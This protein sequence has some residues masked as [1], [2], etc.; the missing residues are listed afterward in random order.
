[1]A[2]RIGIFAAICIVSIALMVRVEAGTQ[3]GLGFADST[4]LRPSAAA[5][6]A[7]AGE[8]EATA[9]LN[10]C[11]DSAVRSSLMTDDRPVDIDLIRGNPAPEPPA[12]L[13][14]GL[15]FGAVLCGRSLLDRK[16]AADSASDG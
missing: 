16:P 7:W 11:G 6:F 12:L 5:S 3:V 1:M 13:M 9:L 8:I 4:D 15:A 10:S 14:V 2:R